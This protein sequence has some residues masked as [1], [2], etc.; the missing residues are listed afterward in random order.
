VLPNDVMRLAKAAGFDVYPTGIEHGTV[1]VVNKGQPFEV[2]T[3]RLDVETDGRRAVVTFTDNW[4]ADALRRDFTINALYCDALGKVYDFTTGYLDIQ[5]KRVRFVGDSEARIKEDYLRILR[6]FRF[7]ACYG[8]GS[9]CPVG[10][11]ASIKLILGLKKIS[12]E[13]IRQE[14]LKLI[15]ATRA[16]ETLKVM[17]ASGILKKILSHTEDWR[18]LGRLPADA[19]LR[20]F[21]LAKFPADLKVT[22][23]LSN[24]EE[25]RIEG[26]ISTPALSPALKDNERRA[27]LYS[28]GKQAWMDAC[29]LYHARSR[30]AL[31][32]RDWQDLKS[33]AERWPIPNLPISG[34]DLL[35][36][37]IAAGP[38]LGN[39]LQRAE[40][41]WVAGDF[42]ASREDLLTYLE[43]VME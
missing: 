13:R 32:N 3:L 41:F 22:L 12:A 15:V 9:P 27:L 14:L 31:N 28:M 34:K 39:L 8:K 11:A 25:A 21:A 29:C 10:L 26:L 42:K 5:R 30:A 23:R 7:H 24:E 20:L 1:I 35:D 4:Q 40:D 38:H 37:G 18:V 43:S 19:I 33:L 2:T 16:V 6:F 36:K 17:T